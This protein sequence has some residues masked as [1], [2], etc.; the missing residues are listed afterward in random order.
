LFEQTW[1]HFSA[2]LL[3]TELESSRVRKATAWAAILWRMAPLLKISNTFLALASRT[4]ATPGPGA[5]PNRFGTDKKSR[6]VGRL[7]MV[8]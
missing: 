4:D 2:F 3:L 5:G 7:L 6:P 1:K 8:R